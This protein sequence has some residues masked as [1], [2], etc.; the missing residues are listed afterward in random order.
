MPVNAK[1]NIKIQLI[2]ILIKPLRSTIPLML[3]N[4]K[5]KKRA[6]QPAFRFYTKAL[7]PYQLNRT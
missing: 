5:Q 4:A 1:I 3:T 7:K 2:L 6:I